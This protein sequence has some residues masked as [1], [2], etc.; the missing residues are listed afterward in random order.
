[1]VGA[2][3]FYTWPAA[4]VLAQFV[5]YIRK[6]LPGKNVLEI[7]AGTSLPGLLVIACSFLLKQQNK[8]VNALAGC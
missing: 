2:Y 4:K 7:G 5:F 8:I 6:C 1:M 3:S